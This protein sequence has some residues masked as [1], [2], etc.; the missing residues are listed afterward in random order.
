MLNK[1]KKIVPL[2]TLR[3]SEKTLVTPDSC[4]NHIRPEMN[5]Q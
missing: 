5:T 2:G 4:F 3:V 1:K